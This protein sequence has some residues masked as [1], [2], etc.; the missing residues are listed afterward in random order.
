MGP[1]MTP[2]LTDRLR[3]YRRLLVKRAWSARRTAKHG[4]L[5][6]VR[7][8]A[9]GRLHEIRY[10]LRLLRELERQAR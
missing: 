7:H 6:R 5:D 8:R 2:T 1:F 4:R 10:L 3:R 9:D